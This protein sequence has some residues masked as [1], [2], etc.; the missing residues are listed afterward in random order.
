[1]VFFSSW[2]KLWWAKTGETDF[3]WYF[4]AISKDVPVFQN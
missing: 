4:D 1:V 2:I 3:N